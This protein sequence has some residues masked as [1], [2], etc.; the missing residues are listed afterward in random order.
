MF[1][2]SVKTGAAFLAFAPA[3]IGSRAMLVASQD[4]LLIVKGRS[5]ERKLTSWPLLDRHL[6]HDTRVVVRIGTFPLRLL[7]PSVGPVPTCEVLD[8]ER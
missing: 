6:G 2:Q 4:E 5:S 8:G 7:A 3:T 1:R